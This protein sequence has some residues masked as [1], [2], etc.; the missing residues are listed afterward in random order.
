MCFTIFNSMFSILLSNKAPVSEAHLSFQMVITH[1]G[2]CVILPHWWIIASALKKCREA[3][4][5]LSSKRMLW[6]P[7]HL[8][9]S[10]SAP[11]TLQVRWSTAHESFNA[12]C[13]NVN[14]LSPATDVSS[15]R[16]YLSQNSWPEGL[17]KLLISSLAGISMRYFICDDSGSMTTND[18][19]R[20][21]QSNPVPKFVSNLDALNGGFAKYFILKYSFYPCLLQIITML[22]LVWNDRESSIS[23]WTGKCS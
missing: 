14:F 8:C 5:I 19:H 7:T 22:S 2:V 17:Q 20:L 1:S 9:S 23:C 18:G 13:R 12:I 11:Q 6:R 4:I 10:K 3:T 15:T 16:G 21:I